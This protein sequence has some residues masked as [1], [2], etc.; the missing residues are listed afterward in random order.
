MTAINGAKNIIQVEEVEES[1]AVSEST[2]NK[3][4]ASIN[5]I[6]EKTWVSKQFNLNGKFI[7]Q[8]VDNF[9]GTIVFPFDCTIYA[10]S[11]S[12]F[13]A[14]SSG[15]NTADI[16]WQ[17]APGVDEGS[18]FS[19]KPAIN[20]NA[21][22]KTYLFKDVLTP[23]DDIDPG[24]GSVLP[25]FS[26]LDFNKGDALYAQLDEMQPNGGTLTLEIFYAPR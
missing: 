20:F 12:N 6:L 26:K 18:I 21:G 19:T 5:F 15:Q 10:L 25:V 17:S 24:G 8:A 22:S 13:S 1:S 4:G 3:I 7:N 14:G 23:A 11:F 2:F 16:H 9:D